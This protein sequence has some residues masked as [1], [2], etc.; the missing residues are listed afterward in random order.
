MIYILL[1]AFIGK[2]NW[3]L[4]EYIITYVQIFQFTDTTIR[5]NLQINT[6]AILVIYMTK[7]ST[8][9]TEAASLH[10]TLLQVK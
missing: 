6:D 3:L 9:K 2:Y 10:E 4:N 5:R 1:R 7:T 8:V